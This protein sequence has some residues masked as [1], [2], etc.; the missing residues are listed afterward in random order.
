VVLLLLEVE[1][2]D[3]CAFT[4]IADRYNEN[5]HRPVMK[6][7]NTNTLLLLALCIAFFVNE[8]AI[9]SSIYYIRS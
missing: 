2:E 8:Q 3:G 9:L 4:I 7:K 6:N 5:A 1:L